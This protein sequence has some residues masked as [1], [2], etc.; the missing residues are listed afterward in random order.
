MRLRCPNC[1]EPIEAD[2]LACANQHRFTHDVNGVLVLLSD[3]F[4]YEL[5]RFLPGFQALRDAEGKRLL[6]P[7][8]YE[9]LPDLP[10]SSGDPQFQLEWRLRRY[11]WQVID[12]MLHGRSGLRIL[13]VGAWNGWLSHRLA[14]QGHDVTAIDY[15][16]DEY[17]G[18][19]ARRFYHSTW[20]AIQLDLTDLEVIDEVFDVVV[21]NRCLQ[22][23]AEPVAYALYARHLVARQGL[24]LATGLSVIR[25]VTRKQREVQQ[26]RAHLQ[27][28]GLDFFRLLKGYLDRSDTAQLRAA[29]FD[30]R[31]YPQLRLANWRSW[32]QATR[33]SYFYGVWQHEEFA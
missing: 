25:D 31:K 17:D 21:L 29:G 23:F 18:L 33:P 11:D 16:V 26:L 5:D 13:D 24:L 3:A 30:L 8:A 1:R 7:A 19:G 2:T 15:F 22:F 10:A 20:Q 27:Q 4:R 28:H 9:Q 32:L 6:D 12:R 14:R